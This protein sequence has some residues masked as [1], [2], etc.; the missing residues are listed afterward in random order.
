MS[1]FGGRKQAGKVTAEVAR[2]VTGIST[3]FGGVSWTDPGVSDAEIVRK[4]IVF[5]ED[6]RVLFNS[7]HLE[8]LGQVSQSVEVI[9]RE[10]TTTLQQLGP[11]V[12]AVGPLRGIRE[13]GRRFH[14]DC[15]E[16]FQNLD[17]NR[18][19]GSNGEESLFGFFTALGAFRAVVGQHVALLAAHYNI[20][21]EGDL[22]AALPRQD[23]ARA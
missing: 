7:N 13:A 6:R 8:V 14:D 21:V 12:F 20:D 15:Q 19:H 10:C 2:R 5:L 4:F 1:W 22:A 16:E 17:Y 23:E 18:R 9:R 11:K 3:P